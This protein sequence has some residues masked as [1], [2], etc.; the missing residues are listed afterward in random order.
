MLLL[1]VK[2][3]RKKRI[4]VNWCN[5]WGATH[6]VASACEVEWVAA[7]TWYPGTLQACVYRRGQCVYQATLWEPYLSH[8]SELRS[9]AVKGYSSI[10]ILAD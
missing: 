8:M 9:V 7:V 1:S 4:G 6:G 2:K 10:F 5:N 3:E